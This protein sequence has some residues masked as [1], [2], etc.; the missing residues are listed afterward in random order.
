MEMPC[1]RH[2][3]GSE[4]PSDSNEYHAVFSRQE[5]LLSEDLKTTS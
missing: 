3:K 4:L 2:G 5:I 1:N